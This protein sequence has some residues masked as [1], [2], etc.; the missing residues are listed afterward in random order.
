MRR[1]P[2]FVQGF[3][4]RHGKPRFYFRRPGYKS[5]PLPG[6]PWSR[7][8]MEV[9]ER[10]IA[11]QPLAIGAARV[12]PGSLR[13]LAV[14]YFTSIQFNSMKASSQRVRRRIIDRF[15]EQ[16][17]QD[18]QRCGDKNAATMRREHVVKLM[19]ARA[20]RPESANG[21]RKALRALMQHAIDAG[22]RT[23]DPTREVKKIKPK[24]KG[25][26]HSWTEEEIA[27]FKARHAMGTRPRLALAVLLFSGQRKSDVVRMGPQHVRNGFLRVV[28]DKGGAELDIPVHPELAETI[29]ASPSGHLAFVTTEFGR[30]FSVAGFGNWFREQCDMANLRHC[31]AHGLRKAAARRLAEAGCSEHEIAA[32]TGHAILDEVRVYTKAA[33]QKRLAAAAMAKVKG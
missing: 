8:F 5:A 4:D 23:D 11:G 27:Q 21:L 2:K 13:A 26:H 18:G 15:C 3:L 28:Q 29:A 6:L 9:Y 22:I 17:D 24:R 19:A 14:S 1:P 25:G 20:D 30:P 33:N 12:K 16:L 32:I 10:A 7:E 31:S